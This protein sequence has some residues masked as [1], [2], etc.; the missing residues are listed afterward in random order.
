M[1]AMPMTHEDYTVAW[2]CVLPMLNKIHPQLS[3][4]ASDDNAQL[5]AGRYFRS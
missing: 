1:S 4:P 3:Q 2:I 5:Y